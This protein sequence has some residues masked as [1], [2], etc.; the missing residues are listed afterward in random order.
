MD[1]ILLHPVLDVLTFFAAMFILFQVILTWAVPLQ[2]AVTAFFDWLGV[3]VEDYVPWDTLSDFLSQGVIAGVGTVLQILAQIIPLFLMI[4][5]LENVGYRSRAALLME[6]VIGRYGLEGRALV[7]LL[8]PAD[9]HR[10]GSHDS[11]RSKASSESGSA[12]ARSASRRSLRSPGFSS[13]PTSTPRSPTWQW[14]APLISSHRFSM[15]KHSAP[16]SKPRSLG[17]SETSPN[18]MAAASPSPGPIRNTIEQHITRP[19][20]QYFPDIGVKMD[21]GDGDGDGEGRGTVPLF[22]TIGRRPPNT[23]Y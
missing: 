16:P 3:L 23:L 17:T 4:S 5:F 19:L 10:R 12:A 18:C 2:T 13:R 1:R 14:P 15:N 20:A 22:A 8:S 7:S 6:Q 21:D 9:R 11:R